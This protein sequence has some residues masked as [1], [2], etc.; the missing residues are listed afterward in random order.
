[1]R[2]LILIALAAT[3][4]G[5]E[6]PL[7]PMPID[8]S[9]TANTR[10]LAKPVLE[11]R[12]LDAMEDLSTWAHHGAG[13]MSLTT[14][15]FQQAQRSLRVVCPPRGS[16]R[17][18]GRPWGEAILRRAFAGE[19]WTAWNRISVWVYPTMPGH[20]NGSV[21]LKLF[22][23]GIE[24]H[25][26]SPT[27]GPMHYALV[28]PGQWNH[29]VWEIAHLSRDKVTAIELIYRQQGNEPGTAE[30]VTF[31]WDQLE[32]QKVEADYFEGWTVWPGR[33]AFSHTGYEA[34]GPKSAVAT[35]LNA[36]EFRLVDKATGKTVLAKPIRQIKNDLGQF[37]VLDFAEC[38]TPGEYTL[39][40]GGI[41]TQ[42]FRIAAN[43]WRDTIW[44]TVNFFYCERCGDKIP[45]V[46]DICH[47]DWQAEHNGRRIV[48]NGGWHDAGDLSQG[49]IN[50]GEATYAMFDLAERLRDR[51]PVL[52]GRLIEEARWGL[53]WMHKTRFGD[54]FRVVWAT[55]DYWTDNRIGTADDTLGQVSDSPTENF[56]ASAASAIAARTLKD[57]DPGAAK[58][59]LDIAKA[60]WQFAIAKL[61]NPNVEGTSA[62]ILAS[63]ELHKAT[64]DKTYAD[65]AAELAKT[66]LA[67]QQRTYMDFPTDT[68]SPPLRL[69]GFYYSSPRRDSILTYF[70]RGHDQAPT[71]ALAKLCEALPDHPGWM[72]WYA[73]VAMHGEFLQAV[74]RFQDPWAMLPAGLYKRDVSSA[75][76]VNG[77]KL[78]ETLYLR[79]FPVW[80]NFNS[81]RGNYGVLLSQTKALSTAAHLRNRPHLA[82]LCQLQL[83]WVVGRNPF[84]QSTMFGEGYDYAPQ[85]TAMSGD[86]VGSLPVGIQT[87]LNEDVPFW[88]VTNCWN[89]KEVWV[90]PSARWLAILCDMT[91]SRPVVARPVNVDLE[92]RLT[93]DGRL[94]IT[95]RVSGDGKHRLALRTYNLA[96]ETV[97]QLIDLR[98]GERKTVS[99][100]TKIQ[101][102]DAPWFA[103]LVVD[104]DA[105][106]R[107]DLGSP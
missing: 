7:M 31:D 4:L 53:A 67:C 51:D 37:Q 73:G 26:Q 52:A 99:W 56:V 10:W 85:Y 40:A 44:K 95:A 69:T 43:I 28:K 47:A 36:T 71:V 64:A 92:S 90:H 79:R 61:K 93:P 19:D 49:V 32:L 91:D 78:S 2:A 83:Q 23:D 75:Q 77:V 38:E 46:H 21:V 80:L 3:A 105:R 70:H 8:H 72:Q 82:D 65:K 63:A 54:G 96:A 25:P 84:A 16:A 60:D 18:N 76:V 58:E 30:M 97:E 24:K 87:R 89:Y 11:T 103:V 9:R 98:P 104:E 48:I 20:K 59:S 88:P 41:A 14:D 100:T 68:Q 94:T 86:M 55:M 22:N 35:G 62:A 106:Q 15:R 57:I 12:L 1:M 66:L 42:P 17:N 45:G 13:Q 50:T 81:F 6:T 102:A 29:L 27:R 5:A 101:S 74:S 107:W 33:I 34:V 39:V